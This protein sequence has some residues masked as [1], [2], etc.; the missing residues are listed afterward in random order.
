LP[1]AQ[2]NMPA[3]VTVQTMYNLL[4]RSR[5]MGADAARDVLKKWTADAK[6]VDDA[7]RFRRFLVAQGVATDYQA[8]LL[9]HGRNEGYFIAEYKILDRI[10]KGRMAGV[11][12]A[13]TPAGDAVALK[14][15]PPSKAKKPALLGRFQR[16]SRL[17]TQMQHPH[18]VRTVAVGECEG[19]H[20]L[21]MEHLEGETFDDVLQRR[22]RLPLPEAVFVMHQALLGLEHIHEKGVVHRDIKPANLMLVPGITPG[23]PDT[24]L[25]SQVK[26]LDIGLGRETFDESLDIL[27][28][29]QLTGEG[30]L[31][32]T[33]DYLAPEQARDA[34]T[35]D[36]RA[37]I[38]SVGCVLYHALAGQ[39]PFRDT[40]VLEQIIRHAKE[41]ARPLRSFNAEVPDGLQK[42]MNIMMAKDPTQRYPTPERAAKALEVFLPA[43]LV[44]D[45]APMV[46]LPVVKKDVKAELPP[47][48]PMGKLVAA[49]ARDKAPAGER[50]AKR[51]PEPEAKKTGDK[52]KEVEPATQ[53]SLPAGE[54]DVELVAIPIAPP[55]KVQPTPG[56][57]R[58]PLYELDRRDFIML[59]SGMAGTLLAIAAALGLARLFRKRPEEKPPG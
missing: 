2:T 16:E 32:G 19:L 35:V 20:Y 24:V 22:K 10:G 53:A 56:V 38:Y 47:E 8:S 37:D 30:V 51:R 40:S 15:L 6:D 36:I 42:I 3:T 54:Y 21:A 26:I 18:V 52:A 31:L 34:R 46:I 5:L 17:A 50:E 23:Q 41:E 58:K 25:T 4:T 59:G 43:P 45:T 55:Q 1:K 12:R 7:E 57:E 39:P 49:M 11:Y 48:I 28:A 27:P 13:V 44:T 14:V 9:A 33:P 29:E